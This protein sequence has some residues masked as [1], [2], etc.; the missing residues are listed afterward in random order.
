[1]K[2]MERTGE[3]VAYVWAGWDSYT[4][5]FQLY[6]PMYPGAD[7]LE[8]ELYEDIISRL[9]T[10]KDHWAADATTVTTSVPRRPR[11]EEPTRPEMYEYG[12]ILRE[13]AADDSRNHG[14]DARFRSDP[15]PESGP[16]YQMNDRLLLT[17]MVEPKNPKR[18]VQPIPCW[19]N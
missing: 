10:W 18:G 6:C 3:A 13:D 5:K 2:T 7:V 4:N 15:F 16:A 14:P 19:D 12:E 1:M 9:Y 17:P 8:D 11:I